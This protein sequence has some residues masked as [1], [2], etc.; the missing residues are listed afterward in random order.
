MSA[1]DLL[2]G[3]SSAFIKEAWGR[4]IHVHTLSA[5]ELAGLFDIE[6]ADHLITQSA[7]RTPQIRLAKDGAVIPEAAY[8]RQATIGGRTV[9]GLI[10]APK[11]LN[12]FSGGATIIFQGLQRY[13]EPLR[14]LV[15]G[16]EADLGHP[17]Q[18][19]AY[20]TP[21]GSQGFA[22]HSDPHDVIVF[23]TYGAKEWEVHDDGEARKVMMT[24][25]TSMYL[26][27]GTPHMARTQDTASLHVTLGINRYT[28]R[29]LLKRVVDPALASEQFSQTLPARPFD[30]P[31]ALADGLRA[32]L[33]DL[34]AGL[35]A[36]DL[37]GVVHGLHTTFAT[38]RQ[39][40][41]GGGLVDRLAMAGIT[42]DTLLR[43]RPGAAVDLREAGEELQLLLGDRIVTVPGDIRDVIERILAADEFTPAD[44]HDR[45]DDGSALVL[46]RRLV[47]EGLLTA[48]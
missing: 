34:V 32:R 35:S 46:A 10:D 5:E 30:D 21:P 20:L 16:L 29:D 44:L 7:T 25:G 18:A 31:A 15:R 8:A 45:L 19:N 43:R 42:A 40:V 48:S 9:A 24:A 41:L 33:D 39:P 17:C 14:L 11:V 37:D 28:W 36:S 12:L 3:D 6:Q 22:L 47:K 38:S 23:Q 4:R 27:T 13:W 2:T 1:L 26:P